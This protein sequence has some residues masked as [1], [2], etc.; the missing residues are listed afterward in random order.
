[1]SKNLKN[2]KKLKR[3]RFGDVDISEVKKDKGRL[4]Y[5]R[6]LKEKKNRNL[7]SIES[8]MRDNHLLRKQEYLELIS[9]KSKYVRA[10]DLRIGFM[11]TICYDMFNLSSNKRLR[12]VY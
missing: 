3:V 11:E 4:V 9:S 8:H 2:L 6:H 10:N 7:H 1:M 12:I 5:R